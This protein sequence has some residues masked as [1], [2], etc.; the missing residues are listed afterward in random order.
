MYRAITMDHKINFLE[1]LYIKSEVSKTLRMVLITEH[2]GPTR[3]LR[4]V[5]CNRGKNKNNKPQSWCW[6]A[7]CTVNLGNGDCS[8]SL[9]SLGVSEDPVCLFP[10]FCVC[11]DPPC[12]LPFAC[13][14][15][16]CQ[17]FPSVLF[18][19]HL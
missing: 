14:S 17:L 1:C 4:L 10:F 12:F 18:N 16:T 5:L 3:Y 2:R 15:L 19:S 13:S 11:E 6:N 8:T 7:S 9:C